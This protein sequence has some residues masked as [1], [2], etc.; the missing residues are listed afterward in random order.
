ME[1]DW[2]PNPRIKLKKVHFKCDEDMASKERLPDPL[3][4]KNFVMAIVG[5]SGSGKTSLLVNLLCRR[6]K[7]YHGVFDR[8]LVVSDS[9]GSVKEDPFWSLPEEN[10]YTELN[11]ETMEDI[12]NR[13]WYPQPAYEAPDLDSDEELDEEEE[14]D[15]DPTIIRED[16]RVLIVFDD[17]CDELKGSPYI[18]SRIK[19]FVTDKR[20][21][22]GGVSMMFLYQVYNACPLP[23]RKNFTHLCLFETK[24]MTEAKNII[25]EFN[26]GFS[27]KEFARILRF[28]FDK[29]HNHF[30]VGLSAGDNNIYKN[31]GR[32]GI[33][34][35]PVKN[36]RKKEAPEE[37]EEASPK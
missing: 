26:L 19:K 18:R 2:K 21:R 22:C 6:G 30:F 33:K 10:R 5:P 28:V 7:Y 35:R 32:I 13:V 14:L 37:G 31:F 11:D 3:P 15:D 16:H 4:R 29:P 8:V 1:F 24:N 34:T 20:H 23:T 25:D 9:L 36:A 12:F 17:T 27:K